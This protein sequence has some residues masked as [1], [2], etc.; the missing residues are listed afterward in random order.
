MTKICGLPECEDF[1]R[2]AGVSV[3]GFEGNFK[4]K[5][6]SDVEP[7]PCFGT[8]LFSASERQNSTSSEKRAER[9]DSEL[10]VRFSVAWIV[11]DEDNECSHSR[12][13]YTTASLERLTATHKGTHPEPQ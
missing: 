13:S 2:R 3:C 1:S 8:E 9:E 5:E 6:W 12:H 4:I 10:C 11:Q 7:A